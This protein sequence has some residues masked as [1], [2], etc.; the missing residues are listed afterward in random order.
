MGNRHHK[1]NVSEVGQRTVDGIVFHS[2]K[3]ANRY[4]ELKLLQSQ[5]LIYGLEL[6]PKFSWE[7]TYSANGRSLTRQHSYR[8]DF[9]YY[10]CVEISR[11]II[12]D[13][14]GY[15][16]AEY[17]RKKKIVEHLYEIKIKEI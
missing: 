5:G 3:E 7:T 8:A 11:A 4:M 6:Q 13:V 15:R 17:K 9:S 12:E 1:Y 2:K 16:T 14:K 10:D